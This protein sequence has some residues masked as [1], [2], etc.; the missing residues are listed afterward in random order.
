M[1]G[2]IRRLI[3][4]SSLESRAEVL[5]SRY[6]NFQSELETEVQTIVE[7]TQKE[8]EKNLEILIND[9]N[10]RLLADQEFLNNVTSPLK[11]YI[12]ASFDSN[13]LSQKIN[14]YYTQKEKI[15]NEINFLKQRIAKTNEEIKDLIETRHNLLKSLNINEYIDLL[16]YNGILFDGTRN[17]VTQV[18][19]KIDTASGTEKR[20]LINI[21]NILKEKQAL[22]KDIKFIEWVVEQK[23]NHKNELFAAKKVCFDVFNEIKRLI[24][25]I[26]NDI[27]IFRDSLFECRND[28]RKIVFNIPNIQVQIDDCKAKK[29]YFYDRIKSINSDLS[30]IYNTDEEDRSDSDWDQLKSLLGQKNNLKA[31]INIDEINAE[32]RSLSLKSGEIREHRKNIIDQKLS[33]YNVKPI[34]Q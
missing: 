9:L 28:I 5:K 10:V 27:N 12:K 14:F 30:E 25:N 6:A 1:F 15:S 26:Q 20:A 24:D 22:R 33:Q 13:L 2:F 17:L 16:S 4:D 32:Q 18:A 7:R 8:N 31:N 29:D 11:K 21:Y 34:F 23:K 19:E 3:L